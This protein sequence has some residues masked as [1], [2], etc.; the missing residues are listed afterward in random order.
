MKKEEIK[1]WIE[2]TILNR[3]EIHLFL[4]DYDRKVIEEIYKIILEQEIKYDKH[5]KE[6]EI[7]EELII[8]SNLETNNQ[9]EELAWL[10][11]YISLQYDLI[12]IL[13]NKIKR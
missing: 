1:D 12:K 10:R 11:R 8:I 9:N 4:D 3:D 5:D 6:N 2:E 7:R 13:D